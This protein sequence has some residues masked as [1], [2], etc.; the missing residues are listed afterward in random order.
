M[1]VSHQNILLMFTARV[2]IALYSWLLSRDR[3]I[4]AWACSS[5]RDLVAWAAHDSAA[6]HS[7]SE[8]DPIGEGSA[9]GRLR[10]MAQTDNVELQG[11]E[12]HCQKRTLIGLDE[13]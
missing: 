11:K 7:A 8:T 13:M 6:L 5:P 9:F 2:W 1:N 10:I 12:L 3:A 4:P